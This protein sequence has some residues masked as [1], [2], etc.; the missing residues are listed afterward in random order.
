MALDTYL[1]MGMCH[2]RYLYNNTLI[3]QQPKKKNANIH[4]NVLMEKKF[5]F[6]F[7][8]DHKR[9]QG[10]GLTKRSQRITITRMGGGGIDVQKKEAKGS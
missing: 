7:S 6:H 8:K 9:L 4:E 1:A 10:L 2:V 3:S 5:Q